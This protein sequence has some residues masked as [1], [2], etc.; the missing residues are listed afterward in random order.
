MSRD[1]FVY[2]DENH[3]KS[4]GLRAESV[5]ALRQRFLPA[6]KSPWGSAAWLGGEVVYLARSR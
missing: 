6:D 2:V 5:I 1:L 3:T 4:R